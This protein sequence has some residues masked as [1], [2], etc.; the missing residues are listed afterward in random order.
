MVVDTTVHRLL[1]GHQKAKALKS[2]PSSFH[3]LAIHQGTKT[4]SRL[5]SGAEAFTSRKLAQ[6]LHTTTELSGGGTGD[7]DKAAPPVSNGP[8]VE[9]CSSEATASPPAGG[10][11][12]VVLPDLQ[13]QGMSPGDSNTDNASSSS[14]ISWAAM[15]DHLL[16]GHPV[17]D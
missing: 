5:S 9:A 2:S 4:A 15:F 16:E 10:S 14:S 3:T 11:E 6:P 8:G 13:R 17:I 1:N 7:R 12:D